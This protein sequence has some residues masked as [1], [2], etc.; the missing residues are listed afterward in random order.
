MQQ[1]R[2]NHFRRFLGGPS[3]NMGAVLLLI[4]VTLQQR[5]KTDM[6][7]LRDEPTTAL[8]PLSAARSHRA[9]AIYY[10]LGVGNM[11]AP[12]SVH[13]GCGGDLYRL[14]TIARDR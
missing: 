1:N 12:E 6:V 13:R 11:A 3:A 10:G 5:S 7:R 14:Q 9:E 8:R 2:Q 4:A